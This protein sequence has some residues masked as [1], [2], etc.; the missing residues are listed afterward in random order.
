LQA[1]PAAQALDKLPHKEKITK[2]SVAM[3]GRML[4]SLFLAIN[5]IFF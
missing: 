5:L 1:I 4:F 2:S 3:P